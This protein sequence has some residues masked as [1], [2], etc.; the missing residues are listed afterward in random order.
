MKK[1]VYAQVHLDDLIDDNANSYRNEGLKLKCDQSPYSLQ[2]DVLYQ[3][4]LLARDGVIVN[5]CAT[6]SSVTI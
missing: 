2:I 6:F 3:Q 1:Y 5:F 4:F